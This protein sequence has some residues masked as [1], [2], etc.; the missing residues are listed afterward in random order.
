MYNRHFK[1]NDGAYQ[2]YV[3]SFSW[4][5]G[6]DDVRRTS[7]K[8]PDPFKVDVDKKDCSQRRCDFYNIKSKDLRNAKS[9]DGNPLS[10]DY[11]GRIFYCEK[12]SQC[13]LQKEHNKKKQKRKVAIKYQY[14]GLNGINTKYLLSFIFLMLLIN[15]NLIYI[16]AHVHSETVNA[17]LYGED[18]RI[19]CEI[20]PIFGTEKEAKN[21]EDYAVGVS[22][23]FPKSSSIKIKDGE[24]LTVKFIH[25][26]K[27][28]TGLMGY[29]YIYLA[30]HLLQSF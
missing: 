1:R 19:L 10:S 17:T 27:Y 9:I 8:L 25:E 26:N 6:V 23:C 5:F 28:T 18:G 3:N 20:K 2:T 14:H 29:F 7:T 22:S 24:N 12:K 4:D 16:T 11:K 15:G 21:E 30:E 13:K